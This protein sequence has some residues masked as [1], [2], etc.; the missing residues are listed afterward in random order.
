VGAAVLLNEDGT[1][2]VRGGIGLFYERTPSAAGAFRQFEM[3]TETRFA[4]DGITP[5]SGPAVFPHVVSS[6]LETARSRTWD[7]SY[8]Y[9][10]NPRFSVHAGLLDRDGVH[11]LV[12]DRAAP[13]RAPALVLSSSGRSEFRELSGGVHYSH[14]PAADL[15]VTYAY[16]VGRSD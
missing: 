13:P 16:S 14:A 11:E 10:F 7:V 2:V 8:D 12:V 6:D 1:H 3:T 5:V 4:A 15:N 9:R